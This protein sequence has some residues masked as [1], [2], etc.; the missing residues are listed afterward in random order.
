MIHKK[1]LTPLK[2]VKRGCKIIVILLR[3][4]GKSLNV[5]MVIIYVLY[6][7]KA[8]VDGKGHS[9]DKLYK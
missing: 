6:S 8:K 2:Y 7:L 9:L 1:S 3:K 5:N 4:N